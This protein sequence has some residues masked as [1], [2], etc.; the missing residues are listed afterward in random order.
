MKP[1]PMACPAALSFMAASAHDVRPLLVAAYYAEANAH[2][3]AILSYGLAYL[4]A[5]CARRKMMFRDDVMRAAVAH[6]FLRLCRPSLASSVEVRAKQVRIRAGTFRLLS[7]AAHDVLRL[8]LSEG[9]MRFAQVAAGSDDPLPAS[10]VLSPWADSSWWSR[11]QAGR[12][13]PIKL[14]ELKVGSACRPPAAI[15]RAPP[16]D[17]GWLPNFDWAA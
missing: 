12:R 13:N 15:P 5:W 9:A 8:R 16:R 14:L 4:V 17:S 3:P 1:R 6:G 2:N 11:V 7:D 10:T